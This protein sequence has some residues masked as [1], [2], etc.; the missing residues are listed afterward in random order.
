MVAK[1]WIASLLLATA[2][3]RAIDTILY[4]RQL[5]AKEVVVKGPKLESLEDKLRASLPLK[6]WVSRTWAAGQVPEACLNV[7]IGMGNKTLDPSD[8]MVYEV[9]YSDCD[10]PWVICR[11]K[12]ANISKNDLT[13]VCLVSI[14]VVSWV[15]S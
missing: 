5:E 7:Q 9:K 11:H 14:R 3:A 13:D 4:E 2:S 15:P 6:K 10:K 8:F 12:D 1:A